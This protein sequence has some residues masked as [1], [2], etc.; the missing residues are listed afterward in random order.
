MGRFLRIVQTKSQRAFASHTSGFTLIELMIVIAIIAIITVLTIPNVTEN[1]AR[2]RMINISSYMATSIRNAQSN[3]LTG[4]VY[5]QQVRSGL[6]IDIIKD[7]EPGEANSYGIM[8]IFINRDGNTGD[9]VFFSEVAPVTTTACGWIPT[10][11]CNYS[12]AKCAEDSTYCG[13]LNQNQCKDFM[14]R[15]YL[16]EDI[17]LGTLGRTPEEQS[18]TIGRMRVLKQDMTKQKDNPARVLISFAAPKADASLIVKESF[19]PSPPSLQADYFTLCMEV[20]AR[21]GVNTERYLSRVIVFDRVG[22][23]VR[24]YA[25]WPTEVCGS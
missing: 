20:R 7:T 2:Q 19:T 22:G 13:F 24:E 21:I 25:S 8:N 9:Q 6:G 16:V 23:Y 3:V 17:R 14:Q 4:E 15:D 11:I 12:C 5:G 1:S 18:V 10:A